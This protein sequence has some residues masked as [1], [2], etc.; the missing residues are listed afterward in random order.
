MDIRDKS[1][2]ITVTKSNKEKLDTQR[3]YK[4]I[5]PENCWEEWYVYKVPR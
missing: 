3:G 5:N 2:C 1:V 4:D